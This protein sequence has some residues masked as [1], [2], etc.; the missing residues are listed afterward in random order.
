[1]SRAKV[2]LNGEYVGEWP[3]GYASFELDL[4]EYFKFGQPNKLA[5]RLENPPTASRWYS[6]AGISAT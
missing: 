3:Y 6:G 1:M 2:W 4:T 5:V